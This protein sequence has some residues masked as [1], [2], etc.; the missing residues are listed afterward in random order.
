MIA[1]TDATITFDGFGKTN[2]PAA[3]TIQVTNPTGGACQI[4]ATVGKMRCLNITVQVGGQIKM[5]DP[6]PGL[7]VGDSRKC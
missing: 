7:A 1:T 4:S 5:C 6:Y 2:L 3:A